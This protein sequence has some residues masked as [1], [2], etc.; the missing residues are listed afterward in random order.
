MSAC[1]KEI[2]QALPS[3]SVEEMESNVE[4]TV[5][6]VQEYNRTNNLVS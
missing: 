3:N 5:H 2:V 6:W 4:R 1:R